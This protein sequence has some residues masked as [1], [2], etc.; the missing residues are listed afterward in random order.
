MKKYY[1]DMEFVQGQN[2]SFGKFPLLVAI[3]ENEGKPFTLRGLGALVGIEHPQPV[4]HH[5]LQMMAHGMIYK[6][7]KGYRLTP[8]FRKALLI[9]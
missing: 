1:V 5:L 2:S 7:G 3:M 6:D 9:K 4:K 8:E